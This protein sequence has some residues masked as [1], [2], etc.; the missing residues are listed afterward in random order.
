MTLP[1]DLE[2]AQILAQVLKSPEFQDSKRYQELLQYL[3]DKTSQGGSLKETEIAHDLFGK[4]SKFDPSTD[5]LIRSY[6]S[7]LR[8]KLEHYHLTTENQFDHIIEIPKGQYL[9]KFSAKSVHLSPPQRKKYSTYI[10]PAIILLLIFVV[11]F[12]YF[13]DRPPLTAAKQ[14]QTGNPVW[15]DFVDNE[16]HPTLI[17]VGDFLFLNEKDRVVG[18]TFWRDPKINNEADFEHALK[19]NPRVYSQYQISE[20]SYAGAGAA[21][22]LKDVLRMFGGRQANLSV[23]LS[24]QLKWDDFDNNNIIF[25]GTF[26]NLYKLDTLLSRTDIKYHLSPNGLLVFR[27][28]S[29][30]WESFDLSWRGGDYQKDFSV[31]IKLVGSKNNTMMFLTGFSEVGVMESVKLVTDSS[32]LAKAETFLKKRITASPVYFEMVSEAEGVRYTVFQ[33]KI[34][35][36]HL[37]DRSGAEQ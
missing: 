29:K 32:F 9:V 18:R 26:K 17:V 25:L 30:T 10:Y 8:K 28:S 34:K 1:T 37:L 3:V 2:K 7:N 31:M 4:D 11:L 21:L 24:S 27:D 16:K 13:F 35:Y 12:Q 33:S 14:K 36:L 6:I 19:S 20:V 23:K 5:P 22:G 15:T